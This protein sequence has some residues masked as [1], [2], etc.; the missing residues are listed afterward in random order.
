[1]IF[2]KTLH[3]MILFFLILGVG[4]VA[5]KC[6]VVKKDFLGEFSGFIVTI[7]LPAQ[8]FYCIYASATRQ[9]VFD[10]LSMVALA[11]AFYAVA[12][13][14]TWLLAKLLRLKGD[15][16]RV[17]RLCFIFGNT[18]FVGT[19]LLAA[20]FPEN[21]LLYMALFTLVDQPLLW[22]YGVYLSTA[23]HDAPGD[24]HGKHKLNINWKSFISANTI[25]LACAFVC[26]L[27]AIPLP[28]IVVDTMQSISSATPALCMMYL[29]A[30]LCFSDWAGALKR[31]DL[32]VGVAA[33]MVALPVI[34][35]KLLLWSGMFPQELVEALV[36]IIALPVMTLVPILA[37][38]NGHEG[39]YAAGTTVATLVISIVSIPLVVWLSFG[40]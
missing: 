39:D 12:I 17:F 37:Q 14:L 9:T 33:K 24:P 30:L 11:A 7:L 21:G 32:Y 27:A 6:H 34:S 16:S 1:M 26:V 28:G 40:T 36:I 29:G 10:N 20:L 15:R 18:G 31:P 2:E 25:A 23:Q 8:T 19:P 5:G 35:G 4:F 22:T 13:V 3:Q 38:K